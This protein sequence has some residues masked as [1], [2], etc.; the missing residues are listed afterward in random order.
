MVEHFREL[1]EC[2]YQDYYFKRHNVNPM[3]PSP[4]SIHP[5]LMCEQGKFVCSMLRPL[6]DRAQQLS[7]IPKMTDRQIKALDELERLAESKKLCHEFMLEPGEIVFMN[8]FTT[9]HSRSEFEDFEETDKKR[10][11]L[12]LWLSMPNSR[13]LPESLRLNFHKIGAGEYRGGFLAT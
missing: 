13:A 10:L 4:I 12:R 7:N 3:Q 9:L 11:L 2:L 5:I 1:L 6:I 8:S